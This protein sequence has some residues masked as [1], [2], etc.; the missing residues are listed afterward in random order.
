VRRSPYHADV[1][2]KRW[3]EITFWPLTVVSFIF[4]VVYSWQVI[5]DLQGIAYWIARGITAVT[6]LVFVVDYI[7]RLTLARP[8]GAW[9]RKHLF[10]LAV[11]AL[12]ALRPLRLLRALTLVTVLQRTVGTALRSRI[13]I[14]GAGAAAVLIWIS[15]LSE[16]DVE[17]HAPGSNIVNFGDSVWWAFVTLT[18]VG[19]GDFFPVT[20]WGRVVA[21]LLMC[22]GVAVV[23]VVTATLS[24][25]IIE[26]AATGHDDDEAATRGQMRELTQQVAEL[27]RRLPDP[28]APTDSQPAR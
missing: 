4:I 28:P 1:D 3:R 16:L 27:T 12:P 22:G 21:V 14:Y 10:D 24:S 9:F 2:E 26:R 17:R 23:G 5:A 7:V 15:A 8:R 6:W 18:T 25:W 13:V 11:V 20:A 19:Y